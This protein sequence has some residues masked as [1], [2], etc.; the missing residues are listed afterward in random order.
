[1]LARRSLSFL[2][3]A[4]MALPGYG[5]PVAIGV[6]QGS[7]DSQVRGVNLVSGTA[8]Y[9]GDV[10]EVGSGGSTQISFGGSSELVLLQNSRAQVTQTT[11]K[12]PVQIEMENGFAKFRSSS[13]DPIVAM[14]GDGTIRAANGDA[15]GAIK[16]TGTDS[17]L[18]SAE[19]GS[20]VVTTADNAASTTV[21]EGMVLNVALTSDSA[22]GTS[23]DSENSKRK[24]KLVA[25]LLIVAAAAGIAAALALNEPTNEPSLSPFRP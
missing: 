5:N 16:I 18:I 6:V 24:K 15:V 13:S 22:A 10:V 9:S 3:V 25:G 21:P 7:T 1:M 19:Q 2:L 12:S 23:A 20:L 4:A 14:L 11:P 17:A 8:L